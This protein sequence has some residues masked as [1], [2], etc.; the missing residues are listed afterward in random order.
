MSKFQFIKEKISVKMYVNV[1]GSKE[2][3]ATSR[4]TSQLHNKL[5]FTG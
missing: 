2:K 3:D 1:S 5:L 4:G